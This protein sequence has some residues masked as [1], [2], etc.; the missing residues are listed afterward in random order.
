M[1]VRGRCLLVWFVVCLAVLS[2]STLSCGEELTFEAHVRPILKAHCFDCH[3]AEEEPKGKLDLRLARLM[4]RG[5]ESGPAIEPGKP[6]VSLLLKR[7][8]AGE[9]PPGPAKVSA[10][11][12]ET[13]TKWIAAGA[14]TAREEPAE[15]GKGLG[16]TAEERSFWAFQPV[17]RPVVPISN[18]KSEVRTPIDLF[19][20]AKLQ[21]RGLSFGP[22]AGKRTLIK[23]AYF[24]LLGLPPS[25][26]ETEE[27]LSDGASDAYER[28]IDRLLASP[29]YGE[30]WGRH[31]LD[32]AGY[33]DSEGD[34]NVDT[35]A[36]LHLQVSRLRDSL[37]E[38]RQADRSV[39]HRAIGWRRTRARRRSRTCRRRRLRS[40]SR[41]V[42]CEWRPIR[43]RV[44]KAIPIRRAIKSS[45][46]TVKIVSSSLLG[47]DGGVCSVSR[48]SVR[49]DLASG[50]LPVASD[51]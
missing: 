39:C 19:V 32:A 42:S 4:K 47:A 1:T 14:K 40:S 38:R 35:D 34:G 8:K 23:R 20:L 21:E 18:L 43:R 37:A 15:I 16:I 10:R 26:E 5:G 27:F 31:W 17:K 2:R 51:L 50:L 6:D 28:L 24:D 3:G 45:A 9:M 22:E 41:P 12:I 13:L 44:G 29:H 30:R 46:D 33:A 49:P 11:E 48:P 36:A 7:I 25:R